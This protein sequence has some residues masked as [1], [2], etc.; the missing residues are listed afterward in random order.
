M[1]V[2]P[3]AGPPERQPGDDDPAAQPPDEDDEPGTGRREWRPT[4]DPSVPVPRAQAAAVTAAALH[5]TATAI[6]VTPRPLPAEWEADRAVTA[7]YAAQ[8]RTLVVLAAFLVRDTAT[9]EEIVQDAFVALHTGWPTLR[10]LGYDGALAYLRRSVVNRSRAVL[11]Q[12]RELEPEPLRRAP[13][14]ERE[15][16]A[17]SE[18][19]VVVSALR[20]LPLRQREALVLRYYEDL[21]TTQIASIMGISTA[22]ARNYIARGMSSLRAVLEME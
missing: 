19:S 17:E 9:A 13:W 11:R 15:A 16:I 7:L 14:T 22:T 18:R 3:P 1:T 5:A 6:D 10:G 12:G 21:S 8:Y 4:T 20:A 2:E